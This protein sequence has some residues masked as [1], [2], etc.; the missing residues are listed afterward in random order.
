MHVQVEAEAFHL[1]NTDEL[2]ED[3]T[4]KLDKTLTWA[5]VMQRIEQV[6]GIPADQQLYFFFAQQGHHQR[7]AVPFFPQVSSCYGLH[8]CQIHPCDMLLHAVQKGISLKRAAERR[9]VTRENSF[10]S[11][12]LR[13][14]MKWAHCCAETCRGADQ[15]SSQDAHPG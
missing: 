5:A 10:S 8:S 9:T 6:T 14:E 15:A 12:K 13:C 2:P 4:F 3:H 1:V 11:F 7:P